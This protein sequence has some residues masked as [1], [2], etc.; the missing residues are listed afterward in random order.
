[1]SVDTHPII[2]DITIDRSMTSQAR[3]EKKVIT[4]LSL[5]DIFGNIP[6]QEK[7]IIIAKNGGWGNNY[8]TAKKSGLDIPVK[9]WES[10]WLAGRHSSCKFLPGCGLTSWPSLLAFLPG[11]PR[12]LRWWPEGGLMVLDS[13]LQIC[14]WKSTNYQICTVLSPVSFSILAW[15]AAAT[16]Q[17]HYGGKKLG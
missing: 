16:A 17:G 15:R 1:M 7:Q 2:A 13:V 4:I 8:R 3:H 10:Y 5:P 11:L 14:R 9:E 12:G 6:I